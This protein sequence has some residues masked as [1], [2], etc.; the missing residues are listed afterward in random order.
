M[1]TN[2]ELQE[3]KAAIREF[4]RVDIIL[5]KCSV[6]ELAKIVD[7]ANSLISGKPLA[8]V[9]GA[10]SRE[11]D[12]RECDGKEP[13]MTR[14]PIDRFSVSEICRLNHALRIWANAETDENIAKFLNQVFAISLSFMAAQYQYLSKATQ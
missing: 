5:S 2:I 11:L 4:R 9:A 12:R 6:D 7:T 13:G 3:L 14:L 1:S 10:V 8:W